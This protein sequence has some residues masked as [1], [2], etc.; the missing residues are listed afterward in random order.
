MPLS[1]TVTELQQ[2]LDQ[3]LMVAKIVLQIT[4]VKRQRQNF[5]RHIYHM[6][7]RS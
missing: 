7:I 5:F 6:L 2:I 3:L 4:I 1:L